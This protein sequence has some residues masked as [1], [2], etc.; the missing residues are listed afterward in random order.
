M[1]CAILGQ[2]A[3]ATEVS[4]LSCSREA[5]S[6]ARTSAAQATKCGALE[7]TAEAVLHPSFQAWRVLWMSRRITPGRRSNSKKPAW[8]AAGSDSAHRIRDA[9]DSSG[10]KRRAYSA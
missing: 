10:A 2:A 5:G 4:L 6:P 3:S 9:I 8:A 7:C 1:H